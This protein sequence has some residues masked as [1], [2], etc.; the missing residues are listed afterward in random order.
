[1]KITKRSNKHIKSNNRRQL[2]KI[3][4]NERMHENDFIEEINWHSREWEKETNTTPSTNWVNENESRASCSSLNHHRCWWRL[5]TTTIQWQQWY[6]CRLKIR[7]S[8]EAL[9]NICNCWIRYVKY[10]IKSTSIHK[11]K[12]YRAH[13]KRTHT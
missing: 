13:N 7:D 8:T 11:H 2:Q 9:L 1:M 6:S 4:I 3:L 5:Q 10:S 12:G